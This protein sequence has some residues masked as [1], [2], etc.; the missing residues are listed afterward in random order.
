MKDLMGQALLDYQ[1]NK[2]VEDMITETTISEADDLSIPYFFRSF[3]EM[4]KLEQKALQLCRGNVL[5]VG[6]GAGSHA[7]Y[8]MENGLHVKAIDISPGAVQVAISRG[9]NDV[10]CLDLMNLSVKN[11]ENEQEKFDTILLLMNGTGIFQKVSMV[12]QYLLH[13]KTLLAKDGQL[14]IDSSDLKYMYD[15][16]TNEVNEV[17]ILVPADRYYG[18]LEFIIGYKNETTDWFP[19]LYLDERLFE[20]LAHSCGYKFKIVARGENFDYLARLTV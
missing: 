12:L 13:I 1:N 7:L 20:Q 4:P 16:V 18:E 8:L 15:E 5:D 3:S 11:D 6:C 2:Y 10:E 14:L 19:W 9:L 17:G